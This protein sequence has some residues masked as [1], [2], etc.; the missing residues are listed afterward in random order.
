MNVKAVKILIGLSI[1][2]LAI[3]SIYAT[4]TNVNISMPK[5]LKALSEFKFENVHKQIISV[6]Q[7]IQDV[8]AKIEEIGTTWKSAN[9]IIDV[10]KAMYTTII[11][12]VKSSIMFIITIL[13]I[14]SIPFV[15][16]GDII[17]GVFGFFGILT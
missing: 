13:K 10:L 9:D 7:E 12:G 2:I 8:I 6:S 11:N 15:A 1:S 3:L 17:I 5:L 4:L 14:A 16:L